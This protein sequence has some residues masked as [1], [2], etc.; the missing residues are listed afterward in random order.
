MQHGK[1][2]QYF[3]ITIN[4]MLEKEMETLSSMLAWRIPMDR[5][6]WWAKVH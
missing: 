1:Y 3:V 5:E 6:A 4:G 2:S